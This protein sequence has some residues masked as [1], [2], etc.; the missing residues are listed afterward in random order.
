MRAAAYVRNSNMLCEHVEKIQ[1]FRHIPESCL[2]PEHI[3]VRPIV[4]FLGLLFGA[5]LELRHI[6]WFKWRDFVIA[7][8]S[9]SVS[10]ETWLREC[11]C[12]KTCSSWTDV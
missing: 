11:M 10:E 5:N 9:M 7:T 1:V 2:R 6:N 12:P 4:Q 3:E 8:L